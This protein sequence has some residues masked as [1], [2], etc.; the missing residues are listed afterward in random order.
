[1]KGT[2]L[3]TDHSNQGYDCVGLARREIINPF[4]YVFTDSKRSEVDNYFN[5]RYLFLRY[6]MR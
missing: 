2:S 5:V 6:A 1:M 4:I 3:I